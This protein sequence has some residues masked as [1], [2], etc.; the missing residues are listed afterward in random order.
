[1]GLKKPNSG[2]PSR[3]VKNHKSEFRDVD[4]IPDLRCDADC[5]AWDA[6]YPNVA[7]RE[8]ALAKLGFHST[9]PTLLKVPGMGKNFW[10]NQNVCHLHQSDLGEWKRGRL[11]MHVSIHA[12]QAKGT[13]GFVVVAVVVL[14]GLTRR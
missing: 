9:K 3:Y 8:K 1:M 7:A 14:F 13:N 5:D 12:Q 10:F 6:H 2:V 4:M 11:S